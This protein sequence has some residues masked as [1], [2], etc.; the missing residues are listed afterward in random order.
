MRAVIQPSPEG[1]NNGG[2]FDQSEWEYASRGGTLLAWL[3]YWGPLFD[4][5]VPTVN[6]TDYCWYSG[7][8]S[9]SMQIV[10]ARQGG[11]HYEIHVR[12]AHRA[13]KFFIVLG[14]VELGRV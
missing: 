2:A 4:N 3:Y 10:I 5:V 13:V 1:G 11:K 8:S 7:N 14:R 9:G 12:N 6:G